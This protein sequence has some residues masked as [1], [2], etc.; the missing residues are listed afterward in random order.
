[1]GLFLSVP[2]LGAYS[3]VPIEWLRHRGLHC[4]QGRQSFG[5]GLSARHLACTPNSLV[6]YRMVTRSESLRLV[7]R[8]LVACH[9]ALI[10][11]VGRSP[12]ASIVKH[13][14]PLFPLQS[15]DRG[16]KVVIEAAQGETH[17]AGVLKLCCGN[18]VEA[19]VCDLYLRLQSIMFCCPEPRVWL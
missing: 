6:I 14:D 9:T 5:S 18:R 17:S 15:T 3:T 8:P 7:L 19:H 4:Q 1:M 16:V 13:P 11:Y 2:S 12:D 10:L